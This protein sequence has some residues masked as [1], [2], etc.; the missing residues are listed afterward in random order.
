MTTKQEIKRLLKD[1]A[2]SIVDERILPETLDNIA[3][4][5]GELMGKLTTL[6]PE[7]DQEKVDEVAKLIH[8]GLVQETLKQLKEFPKRKKLSK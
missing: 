5:M 6:D 2:P 4:W 1:R 8:E 7:A 3:E